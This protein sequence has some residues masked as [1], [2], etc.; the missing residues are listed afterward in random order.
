MIS[1][2]KLLD[3][4]ATEALSSDTHRCHRCGRTFSPNEDGCPFCGTNAPV[5]PIPE[6]P[7]PGTGSGEDEE[8]K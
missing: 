1:S 5:S 3:M 7:K 4:V 6:L 8:N 2:Q